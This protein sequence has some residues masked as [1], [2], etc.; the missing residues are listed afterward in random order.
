MVNIRLSVTSSIKKSVDNSNWGTLMGSVDTTIRF[1]VWHYCWK[2]DS[3]S[4]IL[5]TVVNI[6]KPQLNKI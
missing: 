4:F 1:T 2:T 5:E 6:L 3:E